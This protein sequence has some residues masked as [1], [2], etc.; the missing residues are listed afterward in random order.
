MFYL[1]THSTHF[2]NGYNGVM[3]MVK[4]HSDSVKV[5][6]LSSTWAT[7]FRL[8]IRVLLY[9]SSHRIVL[10]T[11]QS[12]KFKLHVLDFVIIL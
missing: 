7:H 11:E 1:T 9:A 10:K 6:P 2:I 8:A 12:P 4:G 5:N 3:Y